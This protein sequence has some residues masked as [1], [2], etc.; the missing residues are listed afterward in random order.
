MHADQSAQQAVLGIQ[1]R[2]WQALQSKDAVLLATVLAPEFVGRSPGEAD[3]TR[4]ELITTLT[5]FPGLITTIGGEGIAVQVFG[6]VAMLTGVQVA[7]L[8]WPDGTVRSSRVMVSNVF[9]QRDRTWA[10]VLS[11]ACELVHDR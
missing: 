4:E 10:M 6:A 3:Q 1:E 7:Q 9:C 11:H 8:A 2:F 5:T